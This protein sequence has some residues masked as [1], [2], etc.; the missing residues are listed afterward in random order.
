MKGHIAAEK[1]ARSPKM[2]DPTF[3]RSSQ[4]RPRFENEKNISV[5]ASNF[6]YTL[7]AS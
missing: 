7:Q 4:L 3:F 2:H 6:S 1:N 5:K